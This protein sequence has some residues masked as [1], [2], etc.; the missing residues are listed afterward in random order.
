[1]NILILS[2]PA[3]IVGLICFGNGFWGLQTTVVLNEPGSEH[4]ET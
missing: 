2:I 3:I 1:M 4:G